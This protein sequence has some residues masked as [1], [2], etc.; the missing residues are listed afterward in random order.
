MIP[1]A[2]QLRIR[3]SVILLIAVALQIEAAPGIALFAVPVP[4]GDP[5]IDYVIRVRPGDDFVLYGIVSS[6]EES[7]AGWEMGLRIR[8]CGHGG[9]Q[10]STDER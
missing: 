5:E 1:S 10:G 3:V 9:S 4:T 6:L 8:G 2:Q 7:I